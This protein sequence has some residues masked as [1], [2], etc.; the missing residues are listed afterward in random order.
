[1]GL[2]FHYNGKISNSD[3]LFELIIDIQDIAKV[4]DWNYYVYYQMKA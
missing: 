2:S 1:M 3:L 4:L